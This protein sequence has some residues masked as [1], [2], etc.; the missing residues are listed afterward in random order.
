MGV[1]VFGPEAEL[2]ALREAGHGFVFDD[3]EGL[4]GADFSIVLRQRQDFVAIVLDGARF[5]DA[6]MAGLGGNHA[7]IAA[8]TSLYLPVVPGRSRADRLVSHMDLI[9]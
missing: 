6:D 7:L 2:H 9:A 8:V 3:A 4:V 5:V 1:I